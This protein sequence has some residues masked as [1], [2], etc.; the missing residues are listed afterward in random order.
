MKKIRPLSAQE[1][2]I[3]KRIANEFGKPEFREKGT[4]EA[5]GTKGYQ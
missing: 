2:D 4:K 5:S 3:Y 1:L